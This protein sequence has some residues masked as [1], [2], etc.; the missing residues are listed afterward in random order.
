M[1]E[2]HKTLQHTPLEDAQAAVLGTALCALGIQFLGHAQL[3]TGQTAGLGVLLSY[4]TGISFG[5]WFFLLNLPFYVLALIRMGIT[6]TIK[7]FAAVAMVS[8]MAELFGQTIAFSAL[9]PWL[10]MALSGGLIGMGLI[11]IFRHGASLGGVGVL[12][13]YLQDKTGFKAGYTQL[14]FDGV[15][16]A[17]AFLFLPW[18]TVLWSL[19]GAIV[20]N[21]IIATNH[22]KD[23]YV[24]T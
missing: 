9:P 24:A 20:T 6:F 13:L 17:I 2:P 5:V 23:R 11:I 7:S 4:V 19:G 14:G 12:A 10:A 18:E 22:R 15:L 1:A 3:I 21:M 8:V 16:F